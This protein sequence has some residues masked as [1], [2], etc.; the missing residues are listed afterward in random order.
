[1]KKFVLSLFILFSGFSLCSNQRLIGVY[2][3][4]VL[5]ANLVMPAANKFDLNIYAGFSNYWWGASARADIGLRIMHNEFTAFNNAVFSGNSNL[6]LY[7]YVIPSVMG[8]IN[9][10]NS[11]NPIGIGGEVAIGVNLPI[12]KFDVFWDIMPGIR[13]FPPLSSYISGGIGIRIPF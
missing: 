8:Y 1:M 13:F 11:P 9:F 7:Y 5:G 2:L 3:G 10:W 12:Q 4:D 6:K